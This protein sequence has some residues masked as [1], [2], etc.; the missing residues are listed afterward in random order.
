VPPGT[1]A[2]LIDLRR[3]DLVLQHLLFNALVCRGRGAR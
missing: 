1:R 3:D 2:I